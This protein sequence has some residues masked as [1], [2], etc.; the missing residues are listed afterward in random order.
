MLDSSWLCPGLAPTHWSPFPA[1]PHSSLG[2]SAWR[3]SCQ[4]WR[5][6]CCIPLRMSLPELEAVLLP[7]LP[8]SRLYSWAAPGET[9]ALMAGKGTSGGPGLF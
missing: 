2:P 7:F 9:L 8:Q 3:G 1:T 4:G 5:S 6:H